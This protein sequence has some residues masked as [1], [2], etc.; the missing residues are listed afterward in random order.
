VAAP[1]RTGP[2]WWMA[3]A[4]AAPEPRD[5]IA[6]ASLRAAA[7]APTRPP[8]GRALRPPTCRAAR[9]LIKPID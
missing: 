5:A 4:E 6:P 3:A 8:G 7:A 1:E 9:L 2:V